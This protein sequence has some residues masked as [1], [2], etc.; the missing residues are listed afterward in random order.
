MKNFNSLV[1]FFSVLIKSIF[2][3]LFN[4]KT[5]SGGGMFA[6]IKMAHIV[7]EARGSIA[8][9]VFSRNTYGAY[10]RAK[11]TPVNPQTVAQ[12]LTRNFMTTVAQTWRGITQLQRDLWIQSSVNFTRTNV[13][14]DSVKLTGFNLFM[15][16]NKNLLEIGGSQIADAPQP[17][18]VP[19]FESLALAADTG[20][21]GT[22]I[23]TFAPAIDASVDVQVFATAP[24]SAGKQFVKSELRKITVL[25]VADVSPEDLTAVYIAKFGALPPVGS[26]V[27]IGVKPTN[28]T[29]GQAGSLLKAS[30]IAV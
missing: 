16:L 13:F 21:L 8:G 18:S 6:L 30:T 9:T 20:G 12:Q 11:V 29:T 4:S 1:L 10:L 28:N 17:A 25:T 3:S 26:K 27:F 14:G 24:L 2:N 5:S 23:A 15:R 19:G 22:L 7:A